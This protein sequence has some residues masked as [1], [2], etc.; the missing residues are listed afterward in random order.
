MSCARGKLRALRLGSGI[1]YKG[2]GKRI[3]SVSFHYL[4]R[5]EGGFAV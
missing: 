3:L 5:E 4:G 2:K 1:L